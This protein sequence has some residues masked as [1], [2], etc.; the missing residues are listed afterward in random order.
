MTRI[1]KPTPLNQSEIVQSTIKPYLNQGKPIS[2]NIFNQTDRAKQTTRKTDKIKNISIGLEDIDYAIKYYF[3]TIIKPVVVQDGQT[4]PVP[5]KYSSPERWKSVQQDGYYRDTNGKLVLPVIIYK[6][7]SVEKNRSLGN[8]VDGNVSSLFQVFETRYN[9]RNQYD[10]FSILTNRIP[11]K[12][13]YVSVVPDYVTLTYSVSIF[14]NYVEQNNKIIEAIEFAADSYWGDPNRWQ[15]RTMIDSFATTNI[16]NSG[17]DRAA[18]TT[19]TLKVNG[20]L[21][22]DSINKTLAETGMHYSPAQVVFGME[23]VGDVNETFNAA[24]QIAASQV[25]G[26]TSFIG[27]GSNI[28]NN[29]LSQLALAEADYLNYSAA[30]KADSTTDNTA[31]FNDK[32][33]KLPPEGSNIPAP[34]LDQFQFYANG[35]QI[36]SFTI[37]SFEQVGLNLVLT[38]VTTGPTGLG[39]TLSGKEIMVTGKIQ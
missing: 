30:F 14:T 18:V 16:I 38:V 33:I 31:T 39:Y 12:Q 17:E 2:N 9:Q 28:T 37:T 36:P 29:V 15:F 21:I 24:S 1:N 25:A 13:Y 34:T 6:R 7:D 23:V 22:A 27:G 8:K 20:Y 11:S 4:I 26:S 10:N 35:I 5:I 3:D 32:G 19:I